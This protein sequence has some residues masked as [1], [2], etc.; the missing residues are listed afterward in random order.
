MHL[1]SA[2]DTNITPIIGLLGILNPAEDLPVDSILFG[3][4]G[5]LAISSLSLVTSQLNASLVM[6]LLPRLIV[7]EA[8]IP[9]KA[10]QSGPGYSCPLDVF[11]S[12]IQKDLPDYI[13]TSCPKNKPP[14]PELLVELQ[15][16]Y[17]T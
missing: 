4:P 14:V 6:P 1:F 5:R 12:T 16:Y 15:H 7:N 9:F 11:T 8:V 10:N 3:N 13:K 17:G 2:H